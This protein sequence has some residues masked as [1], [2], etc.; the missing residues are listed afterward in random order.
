MRAMAGESAISA[1]A[2]T[3]RSVV[4]LRNRCS[5]F[6]GP[7]EKGAEVLQVTSEQMGRPT[8]ERG[9]ADRPVLGR[10]AFWEVQARLVLSGLQARLDVSQGL[11]ALGILPLEVAASLLDGESAREDLPVAGSAQLDDEGRLPTRIVRR[12]EQDVGVEEQSHSL[13]WVSLSRSRSRSAS[14]SLSSA[15]HCAICSS[16]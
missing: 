9:L 7:V 6:V 13:V 5:W 14:E 15:S 10:K 8:G 2:A 4:R 1:T 12:R 11:Q 16:L 3:T